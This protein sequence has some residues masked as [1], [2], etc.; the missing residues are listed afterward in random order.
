MADSAKNRIAHTSITIRGMSCGH[1]VK[2]VAE[3]LSGVE[4][5]RVHSVDVGRADVEC[6]DSSVLGRALTAIQDAG[7]EAVVDPAP[8]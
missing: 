3:A 1:C 6:T 2:A 4:G 5:L 8:R 7:F